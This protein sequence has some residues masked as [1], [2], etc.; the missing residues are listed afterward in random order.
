[1]LPNKHK[2]IVVLSV[3]GLMIVQ[4]MVA[5]MF[6][7]LIFILACALTTDTS[8]QKI[9][10]TK[11]FGIAIA[12]ILF[13]LIIQSV[14]IDYRKKIWSGG[15]RGAD[16]DLLRSISYGKDYWIRRTHDFVLNNYS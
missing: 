15:E 14:K 9:S 13:I 11:K 1:M 7:E 3:L 8:G 10:F 6:G 12:G 16:P 4:T 5:A 2:K